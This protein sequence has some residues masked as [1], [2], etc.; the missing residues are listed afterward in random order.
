[1]FLNPFPNAFGLDIGDLSMKVVQLR[2]TS[3]RRGGRSYDAVVCRST[4]LPK[5]LIVNG[6]IQEPEKI[7]K[8]IMHLLYDTQNKERV[9]GS[10][11]V[12]ASVPDSQAFIK[13]IDIEKQMADII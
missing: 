2:N 11:W 13:R 5:G 8:Y 1:M 6:V 3:R 10:Q 4:K 9:V 7:R 12:V